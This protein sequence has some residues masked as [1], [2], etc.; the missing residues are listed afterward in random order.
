MQSFEADSVQGELIGVIE[1]GAVY[2]T[3]GRSGEFSDP[4]STFSSNAASASLSAV[5]L[6]SIWFSKGLFTN[7]FLKLKWIVEDFGA[8]MLAELVVCV[9]W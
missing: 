5:H 6:G 7:Q 8:D 1:E 9:A 4:S 3:K 2:T